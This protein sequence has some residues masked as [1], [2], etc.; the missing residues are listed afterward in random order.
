MAGRS[1]HHLAFWIAAASSLHAQTPP[2]VPPL[3]VG[4]IARDAQFRY[5][6]RTAEGR[7]ATG[8]AQVTLRLERPMV[9]HMRATTSAITLRRGKTTFALG[10]SPRLPVD[11]DMR[12]LEWEESSR[13]VTLP[14]ERQWVFCGANY[15]ATLPAGEHTIQW[16]AGDVSGGPVI[17]D[18]GSL[19]VQAF[20]LDGDGPASGKSTRLALLVGVNKYLSSSVPN[21]SGCVNDVADMSD[22]LV[23]KFGFDSRDIDT[24]IDEQATKEKII[25]RFQE[26]LIA[27]CAPNALVVFFYSGHGSQSP[28]TSGDEPDGWDETLI[29]HDS[30][31]PNRF[32][33]R[34]DEINDLL[35][36]LAARTKNI[37]VIFDCCHS[38]T[39]TRGAVGKR[40]ARDVRP[41]PVAEPTPPGAGGFRSRANLPHVL[42]SACKASE[43]AQEYQAGSVHRGALTFFLTR[44]IRTASGRE[45]TYKKLME[46]VKGRVTAAFQSQHPQIEGANADDLVFRVRP[47]PQTIIKALPV[48]NQV[49]LQAG[50]VDGLT[51]GSIFDLLPTAAGFAGQPAAVA[52]VEVTEVDNLTATARIVSGK[53]EAACLARERTHAGDLSRTAVFVDLEGKTPGAVAAS[54]V[55]KQ[56]AE[57]IRT[58]EPYLSQLVAVEDVRAARLIVRQ[59]AAGEIELTDGSAV[60]DLKKAA[61]ADA[62]IKTLQKAVHWGKWLAVVALDN[63]RSALD[64]SLELAVPD[65]GGKPGPASEGLSRLAVWE[66]EEIEFTI[67]NRGKHDVHVS[68][69]DLPFDG[70]VT[71]IYPT[72]GPALLLKPGETATD[73]I[74]VSLPKD[75]RKEM[76][77]FLKL[78]ATRQPSDF[79][80]IQQDAAPKGRDLA[81]SLLRGPVF[82]SRDAADAP[83]IAVDDW[84]A[85]IVPFDIVRRPVP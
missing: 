56:I 12:K 73:R 20:P 64:V 27:K 9:V 71:V 82:K 16:V 61:D 48:E 53:V 43:V 46:R 52:Q 81:A 39:A 78:I 35:A 54:P 29:P 15:A 40:I 60:L 79:R 80:D 5:R 62:V 76:K 24:L 38:G 57:Q 14:A 59:N 17:F 6:E 8:L 66:Q 2:T 84:T 13:F 41:Q 49:V 42:I 23:K 3:P 72:D 11:T 18:A 36:R 50:E 37:T 19:S 75:G 33:L 31:T 74:G 7:G 45:T 44:E 21:L 32:D 30:R 47:T 63:P 51:K 85:R 28:D 1:Y 70:S 69:V 26:H 77:E 34:D 22:L 55:L 83:P 10:F 68:L 67:T 65:R 58:K 4:V 25:A